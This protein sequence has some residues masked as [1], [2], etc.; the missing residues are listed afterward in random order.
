MGGPPEGLLASSYR[1]LI[2]FIVNGRIFVICIRAHGGK[3]EK[4]LW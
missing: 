3:G 4:N 2:D 1:A